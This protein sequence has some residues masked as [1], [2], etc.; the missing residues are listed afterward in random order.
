MLWTKIKERQTDT[1]PNT[2]MHRREGL[3]RNLLKTQGSQKA[4]NFKTFFSPKFSESWKIC[5]E[6]QGF[7]DRTL[8]YS[9]VFPKILKCVIAN[10][11]LGKT[12]CRLFKPS[13]SA[14]SLP[15]HRQLGEGGGGT[16]SVERVISNG[17]GGGGDWVGY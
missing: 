14:S 17:G 8:E 6:L 9:L 12:G 5:A 15:G 7:R 1:H 10:I 4:M 16:E 13:L 3:T 2:V 11:Y